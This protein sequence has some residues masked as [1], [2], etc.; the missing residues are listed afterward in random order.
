MG[1]IALIWFAVG[2][3]M[4]GE[5]VSVGS[6]DN[7]HDHLVES[8]TESSIW[9]CPPCICFNCSKPEFA[10]TNHSTCNIASGICD[11]CPT[12]F[13]GD[14]CRTPLCGSLFMKNRDGPK[15][16]GQRCECEDGWTGIN[17]N[18]C[19]RD[20]VCR[21]GDVCHHGT[22][23]IHQAFKSCEAGT[24]IVHRSSSQFFLIFIENYLVGR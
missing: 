4:A 10:C 9:P 24:K 21:E 13:G 23:A 2:I 14:D 20:E 8:Q 6:V 5:M 19:E 18:V 22:F 7:P 15:K 3:V 1:L 11:N 17:C 16:E 12:G